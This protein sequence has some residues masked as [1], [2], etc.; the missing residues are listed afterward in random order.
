MK[1]LRASLIA[2]LLCS[3]MARPIAAQT[4]KSPVVFTKVSYSP[5]LPN[6]IRQGLPASGTTRFWG[7][8]VLKHRGQPVWSH[9]YDLQKTDFNTRFDAKDYAPVDF[10]QDPRDGVQKSALDLWFQDASHRW[11]R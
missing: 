6:F 5:K 7:R 9:V 1:N 11:R 8:S 10:L 2:S 3:A 4:V